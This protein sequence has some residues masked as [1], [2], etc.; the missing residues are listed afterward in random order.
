MSQP[1]Y[2]PRRAGC[3]SSSLS[4]RQAGAAVVRVKVPGGQ[5]GS[6][7]QTPGRQG[8]TISQQRRCAGAPPSVAFEKFCPPI[9]I[10][11]PKLKFQTF[12]LWPDAADCQCL[13][14]MHVT[15]LEFHRGKGFEAT[16]S[17]KVVSDSES[18]ISPVEPSKGIYKVT[19]QPLF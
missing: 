16:Y 12:F 10:L 14:V 8:I 3:A 5:R 13:F 4:P 18:L 17:L 11:D 15:A 9:G 7:V 2:T 19:N 6:P 1:R